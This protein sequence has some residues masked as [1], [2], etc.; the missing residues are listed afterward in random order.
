MWRIQPQ[1][2]QNHGHVVAN[3]PSSASR[4]A[5]LQ[6]TGSVVLPPAPVLELMLSKNQPEFSEPAVSLQLSNPSLSSMPEG[7][8]GWGGGNKGADMGSLVQP[9][10]ASWRRRRHSHLNDTCE[11]VGRR[12]WGGG[13]GLKTFPESQES[14][15]H[16]AL[17]TP[18]PAPSQML[19]DAQ[20]RPTAQKAASRRGLWRGRLCTLCWHELFA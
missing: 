17:T 16:L 4:N 10:K 14:T 3:H 20:R 7:C 12:R 11:S 18:A 13:K 6:D 5:I 9:R 1:I 15:G 19:A 2:Q 8:Q